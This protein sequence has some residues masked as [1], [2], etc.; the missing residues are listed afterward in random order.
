MLPHR[1]GRSLF[2]LLVLAVVLAGCSPAVIVR[3][4]APDD[5]DKIKSGQLAVVLLQIKSMIDGKVMSPAAA[6]DSNNP[7]VSTSPV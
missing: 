4:S 7:P 5:L 3:P 6:A 1:L 2:I